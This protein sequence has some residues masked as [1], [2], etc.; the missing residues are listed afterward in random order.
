MY[1]EKL[2]REREREGEKVSKCL[3]PFVYFSFICRDHKNPEPS[4]EHWN[5]RPRHRSY[6]TIFLVV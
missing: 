5:A 1:D 6:D 4:D 2:E 3:K